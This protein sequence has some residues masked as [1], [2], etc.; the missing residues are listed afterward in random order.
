MA[1]PVAEGA[2]VDDDLEGDD[3]VDVVDFPEE[4]FAAA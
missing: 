1:T 4:V 2:G 3:A